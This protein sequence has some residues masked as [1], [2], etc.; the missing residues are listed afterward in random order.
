MDPLSKLALKYGTDKGPNPG[1]HQY[2]DKYHRLMAPFR[3][4]VRSVLEIGVYHGASLRMWRDYFPNAE[5][6]G[7]D[8]ARE[9][10]PESLWLLNDEPRMHVI[11]G[12]Q[13]D[14]KDVGQVIDK[15]APFDVVIDDGSHAWSDYLF[16]LDYLWP[17]T[18]RVYIIED[19]CPQFMRDTMLAVN[20]TNDVCFSEIILSQ[21]DG[22]TVAIALVR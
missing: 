20:H 12:N 22:E 8:C 9:V 11:V 13:H 2:T 18:T 17:H 6:Y 3:E 1:W 14:A 16:S 19:V 7:L 4:Q 21:T 15:G 5:I 10:T